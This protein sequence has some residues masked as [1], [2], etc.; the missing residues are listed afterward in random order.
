MAIHFFEESPS[1]P[2]EQLARLDPPIS[3]LKAGIP[4]VVWAEDALSIVHR[5]PTCLFDQQLLV[6]DDCLEAATH[7]I[8]SALPYARIM[9]DDQSRWKDI[10]YF[11][12]E[13]PHSF[14]LNVTTILLKHHNPNFPGINVCCFLSAHSVLSCLPLVFRTNPTAFLFMPPQ[15]STSTSMTLP[16]HA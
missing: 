4:C 7:A 5:V 9:V 16:T 15:S 6:P 3:L 10:R 13:C 12:A 2:D 14:D 8:C 1:P 11:N